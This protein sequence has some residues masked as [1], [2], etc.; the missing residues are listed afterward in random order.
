MVGVGWAVQRYMTVELVQ[1]AFDMMMLRHGK[2]LRGAQVLI[3]SDN[4]SQYA[5][6]TFRRL[7]SDNDF[8]QSMSERGN[9]QDNAPMESF[10]GR[11]KAR[12][13]NRI[14]LC[15]DVETARET[16]NGYM[17]NYNTV[18]YQPNPAGLTPAEFYKFSQTGEYPLDKYFGVDASRFDDPQKLIDAIRE[19]GEKHNDQEREAYARRRELSKRLLKETPEDIVLDDQKRLNK[20]I[21][22][23]EAKELKTKR[24]GE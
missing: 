16:I 8:L 10:F 13:M 15:P 12:I 21:A 2:E 11:T 4:G 5:S 19:L 7:L 1:E 22:L 3:H 18:V 6:A 17:N 20:V 9:S 23:Q 14:A 24:R